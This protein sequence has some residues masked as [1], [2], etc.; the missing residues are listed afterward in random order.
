MTYDEYM[1]WI[2]KTGCGWIGWPPDIVRKSH[3]RDIHEAFE[4]KVEMLKVC[5]GAGE[6][7]TQTK[8]ANHVAATAEN[9]D[10]LFK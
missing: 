9:F 5:Y 1:S 6:K 8:A 7:T 3:L 10:Q 2:I 4:G